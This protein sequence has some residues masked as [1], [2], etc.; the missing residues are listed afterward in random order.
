MNVT[1]SGCVCAVRV[2]ASIQA[3]G[4]GA[5]FNDKFRKTQVLGPVH[6]VGKNP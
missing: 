3:V 4:G 2:I 1:S 6:K 5:V